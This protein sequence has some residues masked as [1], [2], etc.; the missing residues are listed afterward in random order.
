MGR[1]AEPVEHGIGQGGVGHGRVPLVDW[2]LAGDEGRAQP[3]AILYDFQEVP[4]SFDRSWGKQEIIE[5]EHA[6]ARQLGQGP[7]VAAIGPAEGQV[8]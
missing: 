1:L 2:Q 4:A 5:H 8:V 3:C 7:G 6:D